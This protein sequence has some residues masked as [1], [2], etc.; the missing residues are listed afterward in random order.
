MY[1]Y[2][3]THICVCSY[4]VPH[5]LRSNAVRGVNLAWIFHVWDMTRPHVRH[6]SSIC[7]YPAFRR[8]TR[9]IHMRDMILSH[10]RYDSFICATWLIHMCDMTDSHMRH[11]IFVCVYTANPPGAQHD[12]YTCATWLIHMCNM[13]HTHVQ[14][15]AYTRVPWFMRASHRFLD[16]L[17]VLQCVAACCCSAFH[18]SYPTKSWGTWHDAY[19]CEPWLIYPCLPW[20]IHVPLTEEIRLQIF[21]SPDQSSCPWHTFEPRGLRL[22]T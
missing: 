20:R 5:T 16:R 9:P 17:S 14:H 8:V 19:T 15:D 7:V 2:V 18:D 22:L 1:L 11:D 21:G 10:V 6:D 12:S 4:I 3:L 13:A